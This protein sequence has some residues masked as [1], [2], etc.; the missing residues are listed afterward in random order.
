MLSWS[1][2][3]EFSGGVMQRLRTKRLIQRITLPLPFFVL[4]LWLLDRVLLV[5]WIVPTWGHWPFN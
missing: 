1:T 4:L 5:C 3:V 2:D